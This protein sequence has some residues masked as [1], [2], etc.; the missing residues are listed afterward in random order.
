MR[1][2][3]R[4]LG[5]AT[6]ALFS[7]MPLVQA[8]AGP[9]VFE[10]AGP[11]AAAI[12]GSVDA[13]R[14]GLGNPNNANAPGPLLSGRR[15]INWDGGG[16]ATTISPTPFTGFLNTRGAL[17][18][19]PGSGFIQAPPSGL[20]TTFNN[21]T[22]S[23]FA[24]FS[25]PRLFS[26]IGSTRTNVAFF[27]PGTNG[28]LS[29]TIT[30]FGAVFADVD[31]SANASLAF[32]N[33]GGAPLGSF[34]VPASNG[35]LSFLGVNFPGELIGNVQIVSGNSPLGPNDGGAIDIIPMDDFLYSEPQL[36]PEPTTVLLLA[37][38]AVGLGGAAW[39]RHRRRQP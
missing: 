15:E 17:F 30:G 26:P 24:T 3:W 7:L 31:A 23:G 12:Q 33:A 29:A 39:R 34:A 9:I 20:A 4:R 32:V 10:A 19:T 16:Q 18:T 27:V 28:E 8:K 1:R 37:T 21:P 2:T 22:Y 13:F 14:A 5:V 36:I 25:D 35:G 11:D 38:G 6:A